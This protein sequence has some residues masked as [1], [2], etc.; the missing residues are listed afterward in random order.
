VFVT[1]DDKAWS[2]TDCVSYTVMTQ[3]GISEAFALD[4]HFKQFGIANVRP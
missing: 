1:F 4:E 2:F 3:L